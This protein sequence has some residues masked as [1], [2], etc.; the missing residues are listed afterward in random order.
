MAQA[1]KILIF[2]DTRR[3]NTSGSSLVEDAMMNHNVIDSDWKLEGNIR[4][5]MRFN[6]VDTKGGHLIVQ[7]INHSQ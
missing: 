5:E 7:R 1:K 2:V 6:F 3:H 4:R